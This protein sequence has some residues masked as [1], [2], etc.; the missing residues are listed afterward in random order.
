MK[1]LI[2]YGHKIIFCNLTL[3]VTLNYTNQN[4]IF[5]ICFKILNAKKPNYLKSEN[6]N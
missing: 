5:P 3:K 1:G 6:K 2:C 4:S